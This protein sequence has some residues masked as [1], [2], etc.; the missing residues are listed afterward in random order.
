MTPPLVERRC[1]LCGSAE[2]SGAYADATV[3]FGA[4]DKFAFAS[5][6]LPEYMHHRLLN[7][8]A[9]D[10]IYVNPSPGPEFLTAAYQ[11]A[12][13]DAREEARQASRTYGRLVQK[14]LSRVPGR[15]AA[16]DIGTGDGSFLEE[17]LSLGFKRVVGVEPSAAPVAAATSTVRPLIV[18]DMFRDGLFASESFD[19]ITSFQ[20]IEHLFD[21]LELCRCAVS[22]LRPGGALVLVGHNH[23]AWSAQLLGRRS[24]IFDIEHLQLLSPKS[25]RTLLERAGLVDIEVGPIVNRYP[26]HYWIK[27]FP[28]PAR[29]KR[30]L[31]GVMKRLRLGYFP[32]S[33]PVGN[34]AFVGVKS[35][36]V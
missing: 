36:D 13:Y 2:D 20:T 3:D 6:K 12:G 7:C 17:L 27:L 30:S 14:A 35:S 24:P 10:V 19:L 16:L 5:R 32:L 34:I 9:C 11:E 18:Q 8:M 25:A 15:E 1:P 23:R 29:M 33:L 22:L 28:L 4:L 26:L 21:P 31:I